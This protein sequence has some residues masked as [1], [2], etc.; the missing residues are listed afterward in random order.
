MVVLPRPTLAEASHEANAVLEALI[1]CFV[2]RGCCW[3]VHWALSPSCAVC[4]KW[5]LL[6]DCGPLYLAFFMACSVL[7]ALIADI[8]WQNCSAVSIGGCRHHAQSVRSCN[9]IAVA[10]RVSHSAVCSWPNHHD[11][12]QWCVPSA[13]YVLGAI[14]IQQLAV[15]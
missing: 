2:W 10:D 12:Y 3:H 8:V 11:C 1:A 14:C 4:A 15:L 13:S 5:L 9:C 6:L 7:M